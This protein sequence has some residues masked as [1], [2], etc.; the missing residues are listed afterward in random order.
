MN[1]E[2]NTRYK[3]IKSHYFVRFTQTIKA[4][5]KICAVFGCGIKWSHQTIA[6]KMLR[7]FVWQL[8]SGKRRDIDSSLYF[9]FFLFLQM[10]TATVSLALAALYGRTDRFV[11]LWTT[12]NAPDTV[13]GHIS[14]TFLGKK[15]FEFFFGISDIYSPTRRFDRLFYSVIFYLFEHVIYVHLYF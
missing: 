2:K 6:L 7:I 9:F 15:Y 5:K 3:K 11:V 8:A 1:C 13:L 12:K 4:I 14:D 10:N